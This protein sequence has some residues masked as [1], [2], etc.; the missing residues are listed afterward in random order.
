MPCINSFVVEDFQFDEYY[1]D[2]PVQDSC[3]PSGALSTSRVL[4][5]FLHL[6]TSYIFLFNIPRQFLAA[7]CGKHKL[8]SVTGKTTWY[9]SPS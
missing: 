6:C 7:R 5:C 2:L 3:L 4:L 8:C 9:G 1:V